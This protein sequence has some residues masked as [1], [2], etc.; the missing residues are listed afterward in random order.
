MMYPPE[1][2][3]GCCIGSPPCDHAYYFNFYLAAAEQYLGSFFSLE[4][5]SFKMEY[6]VYS[7]KF[8]SMNS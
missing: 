4:V 1:R 2:G 7:G 8:M 6:I 3:F 5:Y